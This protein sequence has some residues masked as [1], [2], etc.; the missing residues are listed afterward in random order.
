[1]LLGDL[2][3]RPI[4]RPVALNEWRGCEAGSAAPVEA[5]GYLLTTQW[6]ASQI[7]PLRA[8]LIHSLYTKPLTCDDR[9]ES[10]IS[11]CDWPQPPSACCGA[12]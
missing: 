12:P 2:A 5:R 6:C 10:E 11:W 8:E 9:P 3:E 1:M 7:T 4:S